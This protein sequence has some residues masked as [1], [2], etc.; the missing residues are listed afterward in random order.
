MEDRTSFERG[1][2]VYLAAE[3]SAG[4]RI[5][6]IGTR[7]EVRAASESELDLELGGSEPEKAQCP[8]HHV[9]RARERRA[10]TPAPGRSWRL[11]LR[12]APV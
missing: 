7:A 9:V 6:E 12:P 3:V 11:R 2:I 1:E 8:T 5:H 4:G 10:R